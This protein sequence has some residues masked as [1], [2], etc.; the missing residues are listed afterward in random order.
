MNQVSDDRVNVTVLTG[1]LGAGKTT[2]LNRWIGS[3]DPAGW[4]VLENEAGAVGV[5]ADVVR[6]GVERLVEIDDG[7]LCCVVR[8]DIADAIDEL[9]GLGGVEHVVIELSGLAD[10]GPVIDTLLHHPVLA[11]RVDVA[12]VIAVVD[13]V[14]FADD[15][16]RH[17]EV[18]RQLSYAD[19]A[20]VT[21]TDLH[22]S[23]LGDAAALIRS[24]FP[25]VRVVDHLVD[26]PVDSLDGFDGSELVSRAPADHS[27]LATVTVHIDGELDGELFYRWLGDLVGLRG[28]ELVRIKGAVAIQGF[29]RAVL[30]QGVHDRVRTA[31]GQ[32]R[33]PGDASALVLVGQRL[34]E[35]RIRDGLKTC[36]P[37]ESAGAGALAPDWKEDS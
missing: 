19:V 11:C 17:R 12:G 3:Q 16:D 7:C 37:R 23:A 8:D 18:R 27:D 9:S 36:V 31:W 32:E 34:N 29:S 35:R 26:L 24:M 15:I 6:Q 22:H 28:R 25:S 4:A 21:K 2:W 14:N 5:D 33:S 20:V 13:G 1:F 10:P 30:V